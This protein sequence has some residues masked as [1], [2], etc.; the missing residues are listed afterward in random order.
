MKKVISLILLSIMLIAFSTNVFAAGVLDDDTTTI[1]GNEYE[2]AQKN[3][4][5]NNTTNKAPNNTQ[6]NQTT[7]PQ[8]GVE[9]FGLG[10]LL[11]VCAGSA[12]FAYKKVRDYKGI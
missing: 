12:I 5:P 1:T 3:N 7:L 4:I 2:N 8:T 6:T 11:V 9:N 10:I